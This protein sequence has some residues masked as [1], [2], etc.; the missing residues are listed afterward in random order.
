MGTTIVVS[1]VVPKV[2]A[3]DQR[4]VAKIA[5]VGIQGRPGPQGADGSG[6]STDLTLSSGD[7]IQ[8]LRVVRAVN[9][10]ALPVDTSQADHA[11]DVSGIALQSAT[12]NGTDISV[13]ASGVLTESG[14][15]W[16]P[17]V[18]YCGPDG[19]LTQSPAATGWLLQVGRVVNA[20]TID[21][22]IELPIFRG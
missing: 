12:V 15:N 11:D 21:I 10:V 4:T 14:W 9:G 19:T 18:V 3:L 7:V 20:T 1:S 13:R 17:G 16:S 5:A 6:T 2:I 22:D 8:S